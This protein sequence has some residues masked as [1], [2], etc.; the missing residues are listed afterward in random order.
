L[1]ASATP[2]GIKREWYVC[3]LNCMFYAERAEGNNL[4]VY[5]KAV[6]D[7]NMVYAQTYTF[8]APETSKFDVRPVTYSRKFC[9]KSNLAQVM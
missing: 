8:I 4:S 2:S 3:I 7:R 5:K 1:G 6:T 9:L